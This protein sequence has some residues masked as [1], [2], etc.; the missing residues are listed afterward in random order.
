[1]AGSSAQISFAFV[2][3]NAASPAIRTISKSLG[4]LS[5]N[6]SAV[7]KTAGVAFGA[8]TAAIGA[9][10]YKALGFAKD[11][12]RSAIDDAAAQQKLVSVLEARNIASEKN[13]A[14]TE[15][16]IKAGQDLAFSDDDIRAGV[17]VATQFT[18]KFS[19]AQKILAAAQDLARAKGI[20]LEQATT[21][22]GKAY[23]GNG[24][25][26]K[27]YGIELKKGSKGLVAITE[28]NKKFAG[29][30]KKYAETA[31]GQLEILGIKIGE[32]KES[33][34]AALLGGEGFPV[35][36]KLLKGLQPIVD[37]IIKSIDDASPVI[38]RFTSD[39]VDKFLA[40]LP[41][42][43][44]TAK[45]KLPAM[46]EDAK[47]LAS[48]IG[49]AIDKIV[50]ALG[51]NGLATI[52]VAGL[53]AKFGGLSGAI[54]AVFTK[55]FSDIGFGP[56]ESGIAGALTGT[57]VTAAMDTFVKVLLQKIIAAKIAEK[58]IPGGGGGGLPG[59]GLPA[60]GAGASGLATTAV[61]VLGS[62]AGIA[63]AA[64]AITG[65]A[66][67]AYSSLVPKDVQAAISAALGAHG[68]ATRGT[69]AGGPGYG[70]IT[71]IPASDYIQRQ[72]SATASA[73]NSQS[74]PWFKLPGSIDRNMTSAV[75]KITNTPITHTSVLNV[76]GQKM[77]TVVNKYLGLQYNTAGT[78]RTGAR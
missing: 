46:F 30:A 72:A 78:T 41:G 33:I 24:K 29:S 40:K 73:I 53:G 19:D 11:A 67:L 27:N 63:G 2:A 50:G 8:L 7:A 32:T 34:G 64:A 57:V 13:L 47:K 68:N 21:I 44:E 17:A 70:T 66:G 20:S 77:A 22:V 45:R 36:T 35:L 51:P 48:D 12:I 39:L 55:S 58:I 69:G 61:A 62:V 1:M 74:S 60:A 31:A 10:A 18:K 15:K 43:I 42:F 56:L 9:A 26:L 14:I 38:S 75:T 65:I 52:G 4:D 49:G 28:F 76:D 5:R 16:L 71:T 3:K 37:G 25:A 54:S 59:V 6:A 23:Q